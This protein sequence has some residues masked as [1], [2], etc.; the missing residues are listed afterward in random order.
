MTELE[1]VASKFVDQSRNQ[2][3]N[4]VKVARKTPVHARSQTAQ[5]LS[6]ASG[7]G[8]SNLLR[9]LEAIHA[10]MQDGYNDDQLIK[11]GQA[12]VVGRYI[13][14]KKDERTEPVVV[15]KF[16]VSPGLKDAFLK[17]LH[18]IA[19]IAKI[20]SQEFTLEAV[21]SILSGL[22]DEELAALLGEARAPK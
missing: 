19:K 13:K 1:A 2:W 4:L 9:K 15:M 10:A 8:K 14:A 20:N 17:N 18:R 16:S 3:A 7:V 6:L 22:E 11:M 21:N 12:A 5:S